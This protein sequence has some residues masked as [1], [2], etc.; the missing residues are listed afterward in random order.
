PGESLA[1][2]LTQARRGGAGLIALSP[3]VL[4]QA[5]VAQL[6]TKSR[7]RGRTDPHRP[8]LFPP[9]ADASD[10]LATD[11]H[12]RRPRHAGASPTASGIKRPVDVQGLHR[13]SS[14]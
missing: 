9:G 6:A 1:L 10:Y 12:N 14:D 5:C 4:P 3:P 13:R 7:A 11:G 2:V 8:E